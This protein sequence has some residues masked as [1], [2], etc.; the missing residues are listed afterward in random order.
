MATPKRAP[1]VR[2]DNSLLDGILSWPEMA[3]GEGWDGLQINQ[4]FV[5][6]LDGVLFNT[7]AAAC[8]KAPSCP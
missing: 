2:R 1:F 5:S 8:D 3:T 6:M 7:V 4:T